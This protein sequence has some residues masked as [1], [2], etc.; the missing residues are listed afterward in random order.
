MS[1]SLEYAESI[2]R[3]KVV[4][5]EPFTAT[6][7]KGEIRFGNGSRIFFRASR[8]LR[9]MVHGCIIKCIAFDGADYIRDEDLSGL[10]PCINPD[11]TVFYVRTELNEDGSEKVML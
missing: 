8:L 10:I 4:Q 6:F 9:Q 3:G 11:A 1:A 2:A 5:L 7:H